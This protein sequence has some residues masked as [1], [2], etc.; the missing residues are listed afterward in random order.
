MRRK[1]TRLALFTLALCSR[2]SYAGVSINEIMQ[3]NFGGVLDYY[4]EFP[5]SWVEVYN[6][7]EEEVDLKGYLIA[8]KY[9]KSVAY[10]IPNS[11]TVKAG[12]YALIFCDKENFKEHTHF[13][14]NSDKDGALYLW[15]EKGVL[16]DSLHYPQMIA[17]EVSWGRLNGNPDSLSH[18]RVPTPEAANNNTNT[19]RV[20][21]KVDF[22]V[23]GGCK[24]EPF[25]LKLTMKGDVP[26]DAVIRIT[27]DG[28]EPDE[29]SRIFTDSIYIY[30]NTTIRA[31]TFSDSAI[32]KISKTQTYFFG[33]DNKIPIINI[34]CN[35]DYLFGN[36]L[37]IC[38]GS[39][40]YYLSHPDNPSP[41]SYNGNA[42]HNYN[43]RRPVNVEYY[44]G[45]EGGPDFNQLA[46]TRISG[47]ISRS[48]LRVKSMMI[49]ANKRFGEKH[50]AGVF[51]EDL[52]PNVDKQKG[53]LIRSSSQ[54]LLGYG[55]KDMLTQNSIGKFAKYFDIDYQ[56]HRPVQYFINGEFQHIMHLQ[57]RAQE[58]YVWANFNKKENIEFGDISFEFFDY[59]DYISFPHTKRLVDL[60]RS[61]E[62][63][64]LQMADEIDV[65]EFMNYLSTEVFFANFDWPNNNAAY[66]YD[67][68]GT[69][70]WR[71]ILRD[72]DA[73]IIEWD[74][75]YYKYLM[76]E[77]PYKDIYFNT[78]KASELYIKMF[79]LDKFKQQYI[80]RISVLTSTV[81]SRNSI[82]SMLE[83]IHNEMSLVLTDKDFRMYL[84]DTEYIDEWN[85]IAHLFHA[86]HLGEYFALG[87]TTQ[88]TVKGMFGDSIIYFNNN[89]LPENKYEGVFYEGRDIYLAHNGELDIYG[90]NNPETDNVTY[91][92]VP[93]PVKTG[94]SL[95]TCWTIKYDLADEKVVEHFSNKVLRYRI[96]EGAKNVVMTDGYSDGGSLTAS[97]LVDS[98]NPQNLTFVVYTV[99]GVC[100]GTFNYEQFSQRQQQEKVNI[101][102]V[103][104]SVGNKLYTVKLLKD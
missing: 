73:T 5:D 45:K 102:S 36:V 42:N 39:D 38:S 99:N 30:K 76:R 71:F 1:L 96:P 8:E 93:A 100:L 90:L 53:M 44:S 79:S 68:E 65:N 40:Y 88:L 20:M 89:P 4:N 51:W 9:D 70:K 59:Q 95:A 82:T 64:Y 85:E 75:P 58:D 60:F 84:E 91:L 61:S 34:T 47:N 11:F 35:P 83:S 46:E 10:K 27:T 22:S 32:S 3:S 37:G 98:R 50:F 2:P 63:T 104:D 25:W 94:D 26:K 33:V 92:D 56:A 21:K 87:D 15:N 49:K 19:E 28:R 7:G 48:Q 69:K 101:V 55:I 31:K 12:G 72:L 41:R 77:D 67:I 81:W 66:W 18:F 23:D 13:R 6:S 86:N 80:D 24:K 17:P 29:N 74:V 52:K 54:D 43:W 14:L 78:D 57:E 16:V 103:Y 62:T 97:T